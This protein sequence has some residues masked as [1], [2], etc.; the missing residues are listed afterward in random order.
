M[1]T[2]GHRNEFINCQKANA[3]IAVLHIIDVKTR[4]NS[5]LALLE[6]DYRLSQF[7]YEWPKNPKYSDYWPL[8]TTQDE[9]T[10]IKYVMEVSLPFWYWTLWMSK[11]HTF[12]LHHVITVYNDMFDHLDGVMGALAQKKTPWKEDLSFA[13]TFVRQKLAK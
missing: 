8:F 13:V 9:W 7:T 11:R 5:T 3:G 6:C 4:W 12:T 1:L 10:I 2:P